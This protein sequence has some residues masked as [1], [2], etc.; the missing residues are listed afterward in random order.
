M[1]KIFLFLMALLTLGITKG[2]AEMIS[3]KT[4]I[5]YYSW[6][7]NTRAVA[8]EIQKQVGGTLFEI[9]TKTPYPEAYQA[10]VDQ[11]KKEIAEGYQPELVK[12]LPDMSG[13]DVIFIGSPNWWGTIAPAVSSFLASTD[14]Q[15]KKV[16]PFI[17]H[18]GG[19]AQNTIKDLTAQCKGCQVEEAFIGHGTSS[20]NKEDIEEW[21]KKV[22]Y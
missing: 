11:A 17:T 2:E 4:L 20:P 10:T 22:N 14:L 6:S 18:G 16:I 12:P 3:S 8:E 9:Q 15:G 1:K 7:G 19:Y 5:A 21:L 13:Y